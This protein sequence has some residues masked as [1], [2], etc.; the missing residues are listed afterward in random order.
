MIKANEVLDGLKTLAEDNGGLHEQ[1]LFGGTLGDYAVID[2]GKQDEMN[3]VDTESTV[4]LTINGQPFL[5]KV[6]SL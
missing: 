2:F 4:Q 6:I 5:V 3:Y 1:L